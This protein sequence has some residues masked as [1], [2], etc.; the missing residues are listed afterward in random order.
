MVSAVTSFI[1]VLIIIAITDEDSGFGSNLASLA[2]GNPRRDGDPPYSD[3]VLVCAAINGSPDGKLSLDEVR[4]AI[5]TRYPFF[6]YDRL[7][8]TWNV[9]CVKF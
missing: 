8:R 1:Q 7:N 6:K 2:D 9:S 4:T 3:R 5:A